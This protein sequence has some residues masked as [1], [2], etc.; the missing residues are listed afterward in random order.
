GISVDGGVVFKEASA[1]LPGVQP[2]E[3]RA[4][5]LQVTGA[6]TP[7]A[8]INIRGAGGQNGLPQQI[9]ELTAHGAKLS[10][11]AIELQRGTS[12]ATVNS[13][14]EVQLMVDRDMAGN[15]LARPEPLT[16]TW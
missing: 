16:I 14:G 12:E 6:D 15:P 11:P 8:R 10:V 4:E 1:T 7:N 2:M 3:I 13:P 9:A 5:H